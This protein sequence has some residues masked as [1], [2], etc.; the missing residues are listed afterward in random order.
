MAA[1]EQSG[2]PKSEGFCFQGERL[3]YGREAD[4]VRAEAGKQKTRNCYIANQG[5]TATL[6]VRS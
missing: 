3:L 4:G 6:A 5:F 1:G 2:A